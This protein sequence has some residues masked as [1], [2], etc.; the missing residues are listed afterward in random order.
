MYL[1]QDHIY[2][3]FDLSTYKASPCQERTNKN[4]VKHKTKN[5]FIV[6]VFQGSLLSQTKNK[7]KENLNFEL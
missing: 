4:A 3:V 2:I 7:T 1:D 5:E 6:V